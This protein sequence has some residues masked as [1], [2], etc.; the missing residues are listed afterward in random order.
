MS[1]EIPVIDV[2]QFLSANELDRARAVRQ[3][4]QAL[5]E[6]GFLT[7]AGH[8]VP[9]SLIERVSK[10]SLDFFDRPEE[11]KAR[12]SIPQQPN[13]G[14]GAMRSRTV[15]ITQ[16]PTLLKSLQEGYGLGP[17]EIPSEFDN[18]SKEMGEREIP[19]VWPGSPADFERAMREYYAH[20]QR[21]FHI[22][23]RMFAVALELPADYFEP[24]LTHS[25]STLRLTH[26]PALDKE[27]LPGEQ[28]AGAHTDTGVL[29]ILHI[30]DTPNSLQV[31]T[32]SKKWI[33]VNR[34]P[35]TFVI[36]IGDLM[37]QWT[38]DKWTSNTHRVVNPAFVNGRSARRLSVVCFCSVNND[39]VIECLPN[40]S[41]PGNPP[42]YAP[43]RSGEYQ[44][45]RA[46]TRYGL[47]APA[48]T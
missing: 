30:D 31:E 42:R 27:P 40:C 4:R 1:L 29:T 14:Y 7:I 47:K 41:G 44:A 16:D 11:E 9:E 32:R 15:G 21:L 26:Y 17:M 38:N 18:E 37:M 2:A 5:E 10:A 46:A 23:M 45:A 48:A 3:V 33:Y 39:T 24:N 12:C 13:R 43:I 34:V 22:I 28:R 35:G 19:N 6:V 25:A 36:N 20:M 8:G